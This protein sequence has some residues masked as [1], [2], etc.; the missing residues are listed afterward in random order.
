VSWILTPVT[1]RTPPLPQIQYPFLAFIMPHSNGPTLTYWSPHPS[2]RV[3]GPSATRVLHVFFQ[4]PVASF[5][6]CCLPTNVDIPRASD[7]L[8]Q[9]LH[10]TSQRLHILM[11][12]N[13]IPS[14]LHAWDLNHPRLSR[15]SNSTFRIASM[16]HYVLLTSHITHSVSPV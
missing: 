1:P 9:R 2:H 13:V 16:P 11:T 3:P 5:I 15:H 14:Y 4:R 8:P 6:P 12:S 10:P 7:T